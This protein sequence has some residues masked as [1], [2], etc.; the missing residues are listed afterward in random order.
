MSR[1]K[2][3]VIIGA[4][5][6][7][8]T[9][10]LYLARARLD[11]L[12]VD[13]GTAGGQMILTHQVA[14]Y[15]GVPGITGAALAR[16]MLGQA[17][18]HGCEVITQSEILEMDL[19]ATPKRLVIEDEG[20]ITA[21][22]V[23]LATGGA[24]RQLG[25]PGEER[26]RGTGVS[27]CA[28]CDGDFF[29]GQEIVAIGGGNSALEEAVSLTRW[30]EKVTVI[31]EFEHFQAQPW[32]VAEA[33]QNPKIH[34][35]MNQEVLEF[36]GDATLAAVRSRDKATGV[37]SRVPATGAFVFIGYV[38]RTESVRDVVACNDRGEILAGE[39]LATSVPGVF[40]A[41]DSRAKRYRQITTATADGTIAALSAIEFLAAR[42]GMLESA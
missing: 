4:G 1:H 24:P 36:A 13:A 39:D 17:R 31:H 32:I 21:S 38:P 3:V 10:G 26:F 34:F 40:A 2:D 27:Y 16:A 11:T 14:N 30:A 9:A 19:T 22:A 8:L 15:P 23:I 18:D 29:A 37:V 25:I 41:G 7:G 35:L 5:A 6:A 12:I 28:T 20:E 42:E 33:R